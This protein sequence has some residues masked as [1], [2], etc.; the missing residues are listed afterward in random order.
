LPL[1]LVERDLASIELREVIWTTIFDILV[2][3]GLVKSS[4]PPPIRLEPKPKKLNLRLVKNH[5]DPEG[6]NGPG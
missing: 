2:Q 4:L 6:N 3:H 5:D 1:K